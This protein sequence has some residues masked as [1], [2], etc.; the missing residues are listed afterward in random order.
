MIGR[1]AAFLRAWRQLGIVAAKEAVDALRDRRTLQMIF[2]VSVIQAPLILFLLSTLAA[3]RESHIERREVY[4]QGI[5]YAPELRNH[6]L[7]EAYRIRTPPPDFEARLRANSFDDA[8][9]V[10]APDFHARLLAGEVP[11]VDVLANSN[12]RGSATARGVARALLEGFIRERTLLQ[13]ASDGVPAE[14]LRP[15]DVEEYDLA[16][17]GSRAAQLTGAFI[18]LYVLLALLAGA[19][20]AAM[21]TTAGE[22]ERASLEPLMM[23]PAPPWAIALGKWVAVA[24]L[25][26]CVAL[27]TS[28]SYL[29]AQMLL[30]SESLQAVFQFGW[31]EVLRFTLICVPFAAAV[32]ALMMATSIRGRSVKEAQAGNSLVMTLVL[33]LPLVSVF[34]DAAEPAW[35]LWV[36]SLAQQTL[37]MRVLKGEPL[38]AAHWLIPG[39]MCG[40]IGVLCL[41]YVSRAL[42]THAVK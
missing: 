1:T 2:F 41:A 5:G 4:V 31:P 33:L 37:M 23:N 26:L 16:S 9:I 34:N 15:V 10:V 36:P 30:R 22:R 35:Y 18:P 25:G 13:L 12:S 19:M 14:Y 42:R 28:L 39:L 3:Q 40:I 38:D 20:N 7:R 27:L 29:P 11:E 21:D 8:V 17:Q 6:L 32:A 24:G